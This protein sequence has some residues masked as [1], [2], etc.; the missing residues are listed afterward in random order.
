MRRSAALLL[1]PCAIVTISGVAQP[2]E[3][4]AAAQ[5]EWALSSAGVLGQMNHDGYDSIHVFPE[6]VRS[7]VSTKIRATWGVGD[8]EDLL[9][10]LDSL[11]DPHSD[12]SRMGWDYPRAILLCRWSVDAGY[13]SEAEAWDKIMPAARRLQSKYTSWARLGEAYLVGR[14]GWSKGNHDEQIQAELAYRELCSNL[15]A[16]GGSCPGISIWAAAAMSKTATIALQRSSSSRI[17]TA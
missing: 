9:D 2:R 13:L 15:R 11:L 7:G 1:I 10:L 17:P 16:P 8:R 14:A 4:P 5:Q 12:K 6:N 3:T